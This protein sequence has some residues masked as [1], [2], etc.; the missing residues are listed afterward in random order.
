MAKRLTT[1]IFSL[2]FVFSLVSTSGGFD[3][4]AKIQ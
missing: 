1:I 3:N 2:I 4:D